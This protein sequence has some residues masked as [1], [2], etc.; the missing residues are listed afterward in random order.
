MTAGGPQPPASWEAF[1][2]CIF[3]CF[4]LSLCLVPRGTGIIFL[5]VSRGLKRGSYFSVWQ[6]VCP[7]PLLPG[8][9]NPRN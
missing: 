3:L 1:W 2:N 4:G 5:R 9:R 6:I 8:I 7:L